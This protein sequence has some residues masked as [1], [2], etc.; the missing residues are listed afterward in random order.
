MGVPQLARSRRQ[1]LRD[2]LVR[3]CKL[4]DE[5]RVDALTC[6]GDLYE[7]ERFSPDTAEFLRATFAELNPMPI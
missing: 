7:Q 2:T 6:A 3:I 1:A 4:A 5:K